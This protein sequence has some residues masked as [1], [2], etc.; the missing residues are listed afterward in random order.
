MACHITTNAAIDRTLDEQLQARRCPYPGS[1]SPSMLKQQA[2]PSCWRLTLESCRAVPCRD[3][4]R[5]KLPCVND[6]RHRE[7]HMGPWVRQ[8]TSKSKRQLLNVRRT[9]N[10][11]IK[12]QTSSTAALSGTLQAHSHHG[13]RQQAPADWVVLLRRTWQR[14]RLQVSLELANSPGQPMDSTAP[15]AD[16]W[17]LLL[18]RHAATPQQTQQLVCCPPSCGH[19]T[20]QLIHATDPPTSLANSYI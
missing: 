12:A 5:G 16:T 18:R 20:C 4:E 7:P 10:T 13:C 8:S 19:V 6:L 9:C 3:R 14:D 15:E 2:Q 1:G 11:D 17:A